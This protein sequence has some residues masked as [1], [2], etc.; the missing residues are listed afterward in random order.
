M[1]AHENA[2]DLLAGEE[3]RASWQASLY[4]QSP[5]PFANPGGAMRAAEQ[6]SL[7]HLSEP[8][9]GA[10]STQR[11]TRGHGRGADDVPTGGA[12]LSWGL[13]RQRWQ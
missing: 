6:L 10:E 11:P 3:S 12:R 1:R 2:T 9:A 13:R 7:S 4:A 8:A 5:R